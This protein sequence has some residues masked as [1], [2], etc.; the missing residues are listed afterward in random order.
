MTGKKS[1][2]QEILRLEKP[3]GLSSE[4]WIETKQHQLILG[5]VGDSLVGRSDELWIHGPPGAG[6][7]HL[8]VIINQ[9]HQFNYYDCGEIDPERSTELLNW[10]D[11]ST[12]LILD[13]VDQW[14]G[15]DAAEASL[16]S[17]WKRKH[18]GLVL[19]S[20]Q[21]PRSEHLI[22]LPDLV[23]R[24][25]ASMIL[26][27]DGLDDASIVDLFECRLNELKIELTPDVIR[28]LTPRLPRNPGKLIELIRVIDQE[29]L[30]D[31]RKI[32]IP[33]VKQLI[34]RTS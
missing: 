24:A 12:G 8:G 16:F 4:C 9:R 6:K 21:S 11:V 1:P 32:T 13:R 26:P 23:S 14:L 33:W 20:Q 34:T 31:Q 2:I 5:Y 18:N 10:L 19:I 22:G 7:T 15:H 29:S 30:R 3:S 27:L 28:F 25:H 17:W